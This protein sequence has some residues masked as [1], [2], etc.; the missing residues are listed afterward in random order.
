MTKCPKLSEWFSKCLQTQL[1]SNIFLSFI[2]ILLAA[3]VLRRHPAKFLRWV[4]GGALKII[5]IF[6]EKSTESNRQRQNQ[7]ARIKHFRFSLL[8]ISSKFCHFSFHVI[9]FELLNF[10]NFCF[11]GIKSWD[12]TSFLW[13][14][15][16]STKISTETQSTEK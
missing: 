9:F 12:F 3:K 16:D 13:I 7:H 6:E 2:I 15:Y 5:E 1:Y 10:A 8:H 14:V 11:L 4:E